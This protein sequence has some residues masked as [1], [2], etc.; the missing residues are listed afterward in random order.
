MGLSWAILL[1]IAGLMLV[2][3]FSEQLVKGVVGTSMHFPISAFLLSVI[4]LGFDP[5][6]L[7][8]GAAGTYES[9]SGIAAGSIIG[10]AMVA[11]AFALGVTAIL[12]PLKFQKISWRLLVIPLLC[13]LLFSALVWDQQLSRW[14]GAI[15]LV[16]YVVAVIYLIYLGKRGV[17][18]QAGGEVAETLEK[19]ELPG[20]WR[21]VGLFLFSLIAL[22]AG[23]EMLVIG[24]KELLNE[25]NISDTLYGMTILA[26]LVSVEEI[27]RELP[28]A[29]K[30][31]SDITMGN[32]IGSVL[33]F[34]FFNAG[35]IALIRPVDISDSTIS[36]YLPVSVGT[37][38]FIILLLA[39]TRKVSRWAG[40]VLLLV[41]IGFV[42]YGFL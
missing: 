20:K 33:A 2:V 32:V 35:I 15:L 42:A 24:S 18:I 29:L 3:Y 30:G 40:G 19:K 7:G 16:G 14:D 23:S 31:K 28:A 1:T 8:V 13:I 12:A 26:F 39:F 17:S 38:I 4:F 34:F 36:F 21:A 41:Y 22:I 5:E 25:F 37:V 9:V 27:A 11:M 6:N 10:A